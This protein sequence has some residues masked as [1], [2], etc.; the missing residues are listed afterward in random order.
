MAPSFDDDFR[1]KL[2]LLLTWRRDVR[3]F[4]RDAVDLRILDEV[5]DLACL[6][7]SVGNSQPW[8]FVMISDPER[9]RRIFENFQRANEAARAGY[10][11]K[12]ASLYDQLKLAGLVE[13]PC[14]LAVCPRKAD[15]P[16]R[17]WFE[18]RGLHFSFCHARMAGSLS[19]GGAR[20]VVGASAV[21]IDVRT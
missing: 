16:L 18:A 8:R 20:R 9:R 1:R 12:R 21:T 10:A 4:R 19:R 7:P 5:L 17:E 11:G 13:A 3:R 2:R 14:H 15:P 6:A